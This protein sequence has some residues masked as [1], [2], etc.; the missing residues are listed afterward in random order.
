MLSKLQEINNAVQANKPFFLYYA[1]T[2]TSTHTPASKESNGCVAMDGIGDAIAKITILIKDNILDQ[3]H[4]N[5]VM[6]IYLH[7]DNMLKFV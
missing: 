7:Q 4:P 3:N 2:S 5:Q 6:V 1:S